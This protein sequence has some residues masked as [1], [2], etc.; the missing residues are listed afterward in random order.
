MFSS[1]QN[2]L[3][4][5]LNG[6]IIMLPTIKGSLLTLFLLTICNLLCEIS[7]EAKFNDIRCRCTCKQLIALNIPRKVYTKDAV[8]EKCNCLDVVVPELNWA[9][10]S[11]VMLEQYCLLCQCK[12]EVRSTKTMEVV[13]LMYLILIGILFSYLAIVGLVDFIGKKRNR[14]QGVETQ[15]LVSEDR[16]STSSETAENMRFRS[17]RRQHSSTSSMMMNRLTNAQVE[18]KR[19][20][21][22]QRD[23]VFESRN[24]LQ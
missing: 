18:W 5:V 23:K 2:I 14:E 10:I 9:N 6:Q 20:L 7:A 19:Q 8:Q 3:D 12:Y 15:N 16:P 1:S 13:V 24:I 17:H 21:K 11:G 4:I 22:S